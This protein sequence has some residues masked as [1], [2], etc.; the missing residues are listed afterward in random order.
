MRTANKHKS[1]T[2]LPACI[3][4]FCSG[5]KNKAPPTVC[6]VDLTTKICTAIPS[7]MEKH[8]KKSPNKPH[9]FDENTTDVVFFVEVALKDT[10][11][12][13]K[14]WWFFCQT[15]VKKIKEIISQRDKNETPQ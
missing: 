12:C 7:W 14:R 3:L 15:N 9:T 5:E 8:K 11:P 6:L 13:R 2:F 1:Q 4:F 10:G